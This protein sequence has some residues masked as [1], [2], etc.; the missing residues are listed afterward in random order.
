TVTGGSDV[1]L[2]AEN[3][4]ESTVISKAVQTGDGKVGVGASVAINVGVNNTRAAIEN[5][6]YLT[7]GGALTLSANAG[8]DMTTKAEA[9]SAGGVALT[10]VAA[11]TVG[12]NRTM[13]RV[14]TGSDLNLA[15][16]ITIDASN[17]GIVITEAKGLAKGD[18]AVGAAIAV[19]VPQN[20]VEAS[21]DRGGLINGDLSISATSELTVETDAFASA[22]G[23]SD[24]KEDNGG[25][26]NELVG[27]LKGSATPD[28]ESTPDAPKA[29]V[30]KG[31][32][33]DK[34]EV[35]VAGA[36]GVNVISNDASARIGDGVVIQKVGDSEITSSNDVNY[37]TYATGEAVSDDVGVGAAIAL[38]LLDNDT[39][40]DIG[41]GTT[42][43]EAGDISISSTSS[44]SMGSEFVGKVGTEAKAGASGGKVAVAGALALVNTSNSSRAYIDDDTEITESG[45]VEIR[46][47]DQS[48]VS[49]RAWAGAL[50]KGDDS[51]AGVGAAFAI[52]HAGDETQAYVG[53]RAKLL[54]AQSLLITA[55]NRK[56]DITDFRFDFDIAAREFDNFSFDD[57][58]PLNVLSSNNYY[59][60]AAAGAASTSDS[61]VAIA[62]AFSVQILESL[63][64]AYIGDDAVVNSVGRS[65]VSAKR[66]T[67]AVALG[68]SFGGSKKV[69]VGVTA[70]NIT[71]WDTTRAYIGKRAMVTTLS[72]DITS[73]VGVNA[74][75]DQ[76][77][78]TIAL[79]GAVA[80]GGG[81]GVALNGVLGAVVSAKTTEAYIDE[82]ATVK[83]KGSVDVDA[84]SDTDVFMLTGGVSA[85]GKAGVGGS[86]AANVMTDKTLAHIGN[87]AEIAAKYDT[88]V[89][90]N[91]DELAVSAVIAGGAG[92][93][94]GVT[95]AISNN[96]LLTETKAY[97]GQQAKINTD[98]LYDNASQRIIVDAHDNSIIVAITGA[99]AGGG[100]AG[101]GAA[102]DTA[103][104]GKNVHAYVDSGA[105][106]KAVDDIEITA[107]AD[108]LVVSLTAGF[109]G[110]GKAGVGGAVS[111]VVTAN[112]TSAYIAD[113]I[114][115]GVDGTPTDCVHLAIT[116]L[117]EESPDMVIS[118]INAGSN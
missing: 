66:D 104:L 114:I 103:V 58:N 71:T 48:K 95:G 50:S 1:T 109:A 62:G 101:V 60:E 67:S 65:E 110:G 15:G 9:G 111:V 36:I 80:A 54:D 39:E 73:S 32:G 27:N 106:V 68:G 52:L 85:G 30:D 23:A 61:G 91:A 77:M 117:L 70:T 17:R 90:A 87:N 24:K 88:R 20:N 57:L 33:G 47:V 105:T 107:D 5:G 40:A 13:A 112:N 59:T 38:T 37:R 2:T 28:G 7:D 49:S 74:E 26:S 29:E 19:A 55:E 108:E 94:V 116:G 86:L 53:D 82:S 43:T 84:N 97:I 44:H 89:T 83:A 22:K 79:S 69:G 99:G 115:D 72:D 4:S 78:G 75:T 118:G 64:E 100:D 93:K 113:D 102:I 11:V 63:T 16:G 45:D 96:T 25:S 3:N 42:I 12:I 14:G 81:E 8:H 41:S 6:A 35:Q 10:P 51:K 18:A 92:G 31:D 34:T 21:L 98:A 76:I 56:V 46:A